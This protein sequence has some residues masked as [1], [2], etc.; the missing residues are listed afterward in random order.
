[1]PIYRGTIVLCVQHLQ[2][3]YDSAVPGSNGSC[4]GSTF[5]QLLPGYDGMDRLKRLEARRVLYAST[6]PLSIN[7]VAIT[8]GSTETRQYVAPE[9]WW[10]GQMFEQDVP[11]AP[12]FVVAWGAKVNMGTGFEVQ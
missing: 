12:S 2:E 1:M 6:L 9:F 4:Y 11:A 3:D 10:Q 7:E 5:G 8:N